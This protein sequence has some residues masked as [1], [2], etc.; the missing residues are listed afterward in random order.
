MVVWFLTVYWVQ[1]VDN[2][3]LVA[4][5]YVVFS[6]SMYLY[7]YILVCQLPRLPP[8]GGVMNRRWFL[9]VHQVQVHLLLLFTLSS[10]PQCMCICL[11]C[12]LPS[13]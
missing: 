5:V 2:G 4:P 13:A 10:P 8:S 3:A 9:T 1:V 7:L 11:V 12:Q 6:P